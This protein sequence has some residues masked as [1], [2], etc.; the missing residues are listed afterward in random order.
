MKKIELLKSFANNKSQ[1][2]KWRYE[3]AIDYMNW[4]TVLIVWDSTLEENFKNFKSLTDF[5]VIVNESETLK[6]KLCY[7]EGFEIDEVVD[8][9]DAMK[10]IGK[11]VRN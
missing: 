11:R 9:Y 4:G 7:A 8:L 10:K 3:I 6:Y 1:I 5:F 2:G